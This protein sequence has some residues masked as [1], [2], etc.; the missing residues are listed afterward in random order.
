MNKA[1]EAV[2]DTAKEIKLHENIEDMKLHTSIDELIKA[3]ES[4]SKKEEPS[5]PPDESTSNGMEAD[6]EYLI[7]MSTFDMCHKAMYDRKFRCEYLKGRECV[8]YGRTKI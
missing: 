4:Q 2:L 5:I 1:Y 7:R 6:C 8:K 3:T